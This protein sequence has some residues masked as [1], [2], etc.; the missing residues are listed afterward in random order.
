MIKSTS[1][2]GILALPLF[3][4]P[5]QTHLYITPLNC[6]IYKKIFDVRVGLC[7]SVDSFKHKIRQILL[8]IQSSKLTDQWTPKNCGI[9]LPAEESSLLTPAFEA[10]F[11]EVTVGIRR[12]G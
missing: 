12:F 11:D 7:T 8:E 4:R 5:N 6:G 1:Q 10:Y 3:Y 2:N 9:S